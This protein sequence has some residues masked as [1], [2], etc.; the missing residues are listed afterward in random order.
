MRKSIIALSILS[1]SSSAT[2]QTATPCQGPEYRALDFWVGEWIA[3]WE[4]Q[5]GKGTGTNRITRDEYGDCVITERFRSDDGSLDGVSI[6]TY[7]PGTR[8][9][10][11]T[12]M[13]DQGGHFDLFG[14]PASGTDYAFA[15]EN[16]RPVETAPFQRMIFQDVKPDS[17]TWRWQSRAKA[18][19]QWSDS[20][21]IRYRRK[22]GTEAAHQARSPAP[23]ASPQ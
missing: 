21:V 13:D 6:S 3:E 23:G 12:W 4:L 18:E 10:R 5:G 20:W 7:R 9:W 16:K 14:G 2:A 17:F 22:P 1:M 11:Q 19:D 8:Q 15:I